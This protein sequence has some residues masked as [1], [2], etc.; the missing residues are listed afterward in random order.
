MYTDDT[1]IY[2]NFGRV[3]SKEDLDQMEACVKSHNELDEKQ[4]FQAQR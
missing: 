4:R 2:L 3:E 1:Q